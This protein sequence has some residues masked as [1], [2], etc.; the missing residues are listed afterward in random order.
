[1]SPNNHH[2]PVSA[3][4][5]QAIWATITPQTLLSAAQRAGHALDSD[6]L[7]AVAALGAGHRRG[8]YLHGAVGRGKSWL[9]DRLFAAVDAPKRRLHVHGFLADLSRQMVREHLPLPDAVRAMLGDAR[10]LLLDEFHVHDIADAIMLRRTVTTLLDADVAVLMTS[11]YPPQRLL[12]DPTFHDAVLPAIEAILT[13]LDIIELGGEHDYR[14]HSAHSAGFASGTW[15]AIPAATQ[16]TLPDAAASGT[17]VSVAL[18][19]T[20]VLRASAAEEGG[21]LRVHWN[22]LCAS[23]LSVNDYLTLAA[24]FSRWELVGVPAPER[25]SA[26]PFQRLAYLLDV[27]VDADLALHVEA[28]TDRAAFAAADNLPRDA[29]RLLS[30]LS[31]LA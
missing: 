18:S 22:E 4:T 12:P 9:A 30:R 17:E 13:H 11:N 1:M 20:R 10:F 2:A 26:D 8:V 3:A 7:Q 27:L 21:R 15:T 23:P 28:S 16:N 19:N 25:M 5:P 14:P 24:R 29:N 31:L 6:Q